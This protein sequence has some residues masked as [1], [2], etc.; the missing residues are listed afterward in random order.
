MTPGERLTP[1]L[2][3]IEEKSYLPPGPYLGRITS[4][5]RMGAQ[6]DKHHTKLYKSDIQNYLKIG[7]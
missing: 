4:E 7:K 1:W 6:N 2:L 5:K 3:L